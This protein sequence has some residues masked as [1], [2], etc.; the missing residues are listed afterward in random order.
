MRFTFTI[1]RFRFMHLDLE[2]ARGWMYANILNIR[3]VYLDFSDWR[4]P[5]IDRPVPFGENPMH[6][7][8][9]RSGSSRAGEVV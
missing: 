5:V 3:V 1:H 4:Y 8:K 6:G 9:H 7:E 2:L